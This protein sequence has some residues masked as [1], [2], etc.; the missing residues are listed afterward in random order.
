MVARAIVVDCARL[1]DADLGQV[2][3]LARA[4]LQTR[5][6]GCSVILANPKPELVEL[7]DFCGLAR[8]LS[9]EMQGQA[10]ER[11]ESLGVEEERELDDSSL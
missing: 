3:R 2:D 5:R 11:E 6:R 7:I 1:G 9:V 10:E 8:V 4:A